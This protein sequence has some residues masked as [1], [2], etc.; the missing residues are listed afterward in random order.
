MT[1]ILQANLNRSRTAD[2]LLHQ[3]AYE[4]KADLVI[5]SEQYQNKSS[6]SWYYDELGTSAIWIRDP[7][8]FTVRSHGRGKGFVW[9]ES[10]GVTYISCYL[11]PNERI[12]PFRCKVNSLE[13]EI[14]KMA[15]KTII[16]GDFNAKSPEWGMPTT[17]SRGNYI[18]EM[19][20]RRGL[21]VLNI[22]ST[23]T[24]RRPGYG[25]TIP[26]I[27]FATE[28]I[29]P[30]V[31]NW[32]VLEDYTGSDH[33]YITFGLCE[34]RGASR[35]ATQDQGR[36][37]VGK[38]DENRFGLSLRNSR[39]VQGLVTDEREQGGAETFVEKT[40]TLLRRA[41]ELSMPRY[42]RGRNKRPVYWWTAEIADL[43]RNCLRLRRRAQRVRDRDEANRLSA[44]HKIAKTK[45]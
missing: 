39:L 45:E 42:G 43:R 28:D 22:G 35:S 20:A 17:D 14:L 31:E 34:S 18:A 26:D 19:A 23:T 44:E 38:L 16:A 10:G 12:Q 5:I 30:L 24:F 1:R 40:M 8:R 21:V 29:L 25:E 2:A 7:A 33:Q 9:V 13:D 41:C 37:N 15:G 36:W 11:T 3:L 27:S 6:A 32:K 4:H